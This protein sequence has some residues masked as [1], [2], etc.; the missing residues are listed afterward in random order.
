MKEE[1]R[2]VVDHEG[3][4]E[5]SSLGRVRSLPKRSVPVATIMNLHPDARG[6]LKAVLSRGSADFHLRVHCMVLEAFVGPRPPGMEGA[7]GDGD[8]SNNVLA[9][10]RWSTPAGN[11]A[12]RDLHGTSNKGER[13]G[14]AKLTDAIVREIRQSD[15]SGAALARRLNVSQATVSLVRRRKIWAHVA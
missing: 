7:H 6:Y 15:E 10:L 13:H 8:K 4:Y 9:N 1:W 3:R 14:N 2:A 12:D 11:Q 5:V